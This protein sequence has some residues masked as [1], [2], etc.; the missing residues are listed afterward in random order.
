V[1][2]KRYPVEL[3]ARASE[4][5]F[6]AE[7]NVLQSE[8]R[9]VFAGAGLFDGFA[10]IFESASCYDDGKIFDVKLDR[11]VRKEIRSTLRS[12]GQNPRSHSDR[13]AVPVVTC[14][15]VILC[16][17]VPRSSARQRSSSRFLPRSARS[18]TCSIPRLH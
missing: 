15:I 5:F 18:E 13:R 7:I 2:Q 10:F 17:H 3:K 14:D 4:T 6:L 1:P 8:L 11:A 12:P 16:L 9:K